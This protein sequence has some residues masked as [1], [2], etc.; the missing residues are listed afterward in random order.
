MYSALLYS[1][2]YISESFYPPGEKHNSYSIALSKDSEL[3]MN[4]GNGHKYA[5]YTGGYNI[6]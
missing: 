3:A 4:R 5:A 2:N 1:Q 6:L